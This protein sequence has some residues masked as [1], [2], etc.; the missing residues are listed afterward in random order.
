MGARVGRRERQQDMGGPSPFPLMT[1]KRTLP[2][3]K[4]KVLSPLQHQL[5]YRSRNLNQKRVQKSQKLK[6]SLNQNLSLNLNRSLNLNL[7]L[8]LNQNQNQSLNLSLSQNLSQKV[9]QSR[10]LLEEPPGL[11]RESSMA[12]TA[13]TW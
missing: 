1:G 12:W 9:H 6:V 7:S 11:Q 4:L 13:Q 3:L 2:L 5:L 10:E 8:N